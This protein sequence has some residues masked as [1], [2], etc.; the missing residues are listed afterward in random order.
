M[1]VGPFRGVDHFKKGKLYKEGWGEGYFGKNV[2]R[3]VHLL[4][5]GGDIE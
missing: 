4:N 3:K 1:L 5:A 2:R